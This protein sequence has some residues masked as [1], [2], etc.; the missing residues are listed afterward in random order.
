MKW[1]GRH[2]ETRASRGSLQKQQGGETSL[3]VQFG[4]SPKPGEK[5]EER[6]SLKMPE[7]E[8]IFAKDRFFLEEVARR[9]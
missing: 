9:E 1:E 5:L 8:G 2:H 7:E 4:K 6:E 3:L